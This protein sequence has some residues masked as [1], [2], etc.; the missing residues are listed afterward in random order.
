MSTPS[1]TQALEHILSATA[2]ELEETQLFAIV[3]GARS[4]LVVPELKASGQPSSCLYDGDLPPALALC[5]PYLVEL[6]K[7]DNAFAEW[8]LVE[9]WG[10]SRGIFLLSDKTRG[11]LRKH[12]RTF[13]MVKRGGK[14]VYFRYYDPRVLR[15][16][17]P[18]CNAE[19]LEF[20][21]GPVQA[22]LCEGETP[23][24]ILRYSRVEGELVTEEVATGAPLPEEAP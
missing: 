19:E 5:A 2:K 23:E 6:G 22:F 21:F 1:G 20:V 15:R 10:D 8:L 3:D 14:S 12:F 11:L 24:T 18:T 13:L 17:L 16:Y 4:E 7:G 9:G